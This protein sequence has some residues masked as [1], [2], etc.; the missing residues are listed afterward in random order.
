MW[1]LLFPVTGCTLGPKGSVTPPGAGLINPLEE[2]AFVSE[3]PSLLDELDSSVL[4][5]FV[6][7]LLLLSLFTLTLFFSLIKL[8]I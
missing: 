2:L 8:F 6:L 1:T 4:L 3:F 5:L 7:L